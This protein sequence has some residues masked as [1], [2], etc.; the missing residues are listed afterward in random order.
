MR[1]NFQ[2]SENINNDNDHTSTKKLCPLFN[3]LRSY[4]ISTWL[5]KVIALAFSN[6]LIYFFYF[7]FLFIWYHKRAR[8]NKVNY[9]HTIQKDP[10]PMTDVR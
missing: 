6:M 7:I 3:H 1:I 10:G 8:A 2:K 4:P 5:N 9:L